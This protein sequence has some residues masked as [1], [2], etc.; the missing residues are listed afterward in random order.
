MLTVDFFIYLFLGFYLENVVPLEFGTAKPFYFLFTKKYWVGDSESSLGRNKVY[1]AS[2]REMIGNRENFEDESNYSDKIK[3]GECL[4]IKNLNKKFEDGKVAVNNLSINMYKNE[5][6][7][8]LGHNGAG[9]STLISILSGLYPATEGEAFYQNE[10]LFY[11]MDGFRKKVGIC[12]QHNVLFEQLSV[13]EHLELFS[14]FKGVEYEDLDNDVNKILEQMDIENLKDSEAG[15]LSGGQKRKLSIAIA[16]VGGSEVVFLD[17]PSSGMDITSRRK[18]WDVL[19]RC[20]TDRIIVLTT[21]YMEEAA[22]LGNR[23]GIISEGELQ[24]SGT[25]L[26]L[27]NRFGKYFNLSFQINEQTDLAKLKNFIKENFDQSSFDEYTEE[28][29]FQVLRSQDLNLKEFFVQLDQK[30]SELGVKSYS[31][32]LP[33]LEDVFLTVANNEHEKQKKE[34]QND[35]V[36]SL[37]EQEN[38]PNDIAYTYNALTSAEVS[39]VTKFLLDLKYSFRKRLL[40]MLRDGKVFLFEILCPIILVI[41][42]LG[43]SGVDFLTASPSIIMNVSGFVNQTIMVNK[44]PLVAN[45][46]GIAT[47]NSFLSQYDTVNYSY[48]LM[49]WTASN[50]NVTD[51]IVR[52]NKYLQSLNSTTQHGNFLI[53]KINKDIQQYEFILFANLYSTDAPAMYI[54][55][56]LNKILIYATDMPNLKIIVSFIT[57]NVLLLL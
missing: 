41:I 27:I 32:S 8:L 57:F 31:V 28:I 54:N 53:T 52:Y 49:D 4:S 50:G 30:I 6:F 48:N 43:V 38:S 21:H 40:Q 26:F 15:T 35:N 10:N 37:R 17:E 22:V 45:T 11:N 5:I 7:A 36:I 14:I 12:P 20:I 23:V 9:K 33:T 2:G 25:P 42:G 44:V 46:N 56:M 39:A 24:C 29:N 1:P 16:L 18:L 19:K 3:T 34:V 13:K 55:E 47:N 51:A